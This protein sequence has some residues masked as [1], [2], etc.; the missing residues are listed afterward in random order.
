M[1]FSRELGLEIMHFNLEELDICESCS[2]VKHRK[3]EKDQ[4]FPKPLA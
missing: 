1:D 2:C 3:L 4:L